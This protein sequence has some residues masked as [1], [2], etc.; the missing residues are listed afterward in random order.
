MGKTRIKV[1]ATATKG[2]IIEIKTLTEHP[3]ESGQRKNAEGKQI[4]RKILNRLVCTFGGKPVFEA[5]MQPA[6]SSNPYMAF[7][8]RVE[9][10]GTFEF[11]WTD[12]D[13]TTFT[14]KAEIKVG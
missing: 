11:T 13:G 10:S 7:F 5:R 3:M 9:E 4:P 8:A 6:I 14:E 1:P 2:Q 12:D